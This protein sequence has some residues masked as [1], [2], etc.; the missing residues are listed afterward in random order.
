ML[1]DT[2]RNMLPTTTCRM[3]SRYGRLR[4]CWKSSITSRSRPSAATVRIAPI[5]STASAVERAY[6]VSWRF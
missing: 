2:A 5:A 3:L 4:L 1:S 6:T